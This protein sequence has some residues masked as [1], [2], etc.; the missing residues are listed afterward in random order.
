MRQ[1]T[2]ITKSLQ[3]VTEVYYKV[4]QV[5]QSASGITKCDRLLLQSASGITKC[6][7]YYKVR[8]NKAPIL[9]YGGAGIRLEFKGDLLRQNKV[10]YNDG[11]IVNIYIAYEISSTF[12]IQSSF[13]LKNS[14]FGAVKITKR[15]DISKYR[16]SGYGIDFNSKGSFFTCKWNIWCKCNNF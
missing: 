2:V 9:E 6:D 1:K 10:T 11:K 14:L 12:T 16:Y 13:T 5:L 3:S 7:S 8:R 15:A 4:R